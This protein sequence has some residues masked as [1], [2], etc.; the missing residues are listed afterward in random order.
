MSEIDRIVQLG[1]AYAN[2]ARDSISET[3]ESRAVRELEESLND[4]VE[5][6]TIRKVEPVVPITDEEARV[7]LGVA[8]NAS[9]SEIKAQHTLLNEHLSTFKQKYPEKAETASRESTRIE[10]AYQLLLAKA[11]P[12][13]KRFGSLEI[14]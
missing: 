7:I 12:T 14:E 8:T 13:E 4:P 5:V 2:K 11:D 6:V 3:P 10:R 9:F 1:R